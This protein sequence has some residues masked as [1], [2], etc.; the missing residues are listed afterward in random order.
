MTRP[1]AARGARRRFLPIAVAILFGLLFTYDLVEAI[2]NLVGLPAQLAVANQFADD[3]GLARIGVPWDILIA[4]TVLPVA[5]FALAWWA[6]RRRS[7][8]HQAMLYLAALAT[9]A[10]VT[11]TL[12]ALV[13]AR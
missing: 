5:A 2:T 1:T 7:V 13:N 12:T 10:A 8:G 11:L 6:G 9:V 3:N 4:N